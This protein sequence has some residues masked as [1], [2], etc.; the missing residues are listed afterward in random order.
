MQHYDL[1]LNIESDLSDALILAKEVFEPS[2]KELAEYHQEAHWREKMRHGGLLVTAWKN[3]TM[4]GFVIC[5]H[6]EERTLHVWNAGVHHPHR[7]RGVW[8]TMYAAIENFASRAG[9]DRITLNTS[10][11]RFPNMYAFVKNHGFKEYRTE[12]QNEKEKSYWGKMI[13]TT[14]MQ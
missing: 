6:R 2:E 1:R 4:I 13:S 11:E 8:S 10:R 14:G 5:D 9:Y 12:T 7:G 3:G